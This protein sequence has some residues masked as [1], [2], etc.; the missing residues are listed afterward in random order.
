MNE[1][2]VNTRKR[3]DTLIES[4]YDAAVKLIKEVGYAN[5]TFQQIAKAAKTSRS[6]LYRRWA[7]MFDLLMEIVDDRSS[8]ALGGQLIDRIKNTGTL[9]GDLL[10]LLTIYQSIYAEIGPEILSAVL[11]E[12]G[13][14]N[15][16]V[17]EA[18][19]DA[20]AKNILVM[21]KLLKNAKSRGEKIKEVSDIT[22]TLPFNLI[23]MENL[24]YKNVDSNQIAL[25]VDEILL[26]VFTV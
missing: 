18:E 25:F 23:R 9:R 7:N 22:L 2:I 13:Q 3:G 17:P 5:L 10:N 16:K 12:I 21:R 8:K 1:K 6:V 26:P 19:V 24:M 4:I 20:E 15:S 11:F 14:G